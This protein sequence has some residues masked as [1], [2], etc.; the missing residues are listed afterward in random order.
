[1]SGSGETNSRHSLRLT[2]LG[3]RRLREQNIDDVVTVEITSPAEHRLGYVI[4]QGAAEDELTALAVEA[5]A[6]KR[7]CRF[8]DVMLAVVAFAQRKELHQLAR[9]DS[10]S[11]RPFGSVRCRGRRSS[12]D[13]ARRRAALRRSCRA[14]LSAGNV[15][16]I[17]AAAVSLTF[18]WLDTK[19]LCQNSVI[20]SVSGEGVDSIS[21]THHPRRDRGLARTCSWRDILSSSSDAPA[22]DAGRP[23]ARARPSPAAAVLPPRCAVASSAL[24][25]CSR[26]ADI[27]SDLGF[28]WRRTPCG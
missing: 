19:W 18:C 1:M 5:P 9:E 23:A 17:H 13:R 22:R 25:A 15:L 20:R 24:A 21:S 4:V 2:N 16:P 28:A 27:V 7:A 3:G 10:R 12:P 11:A 8:L 6:G 14:H 26:H